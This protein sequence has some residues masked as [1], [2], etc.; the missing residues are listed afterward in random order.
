MTKLD[1]MTKIAL[2]AVIVGFVAKISVFAIT[3]QSYMML[4]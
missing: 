2:V 4:P 3:G 1:T